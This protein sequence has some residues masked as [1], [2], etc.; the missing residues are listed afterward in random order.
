MRLEPIF[1]VDWRYDRM[2]AIKP[3][4]TGDGRMYGRGDA[5]FRGKLE[6]PAD[7]SNF[8]RLHQQYA[9]PDARG[10]VSVGGEQFVL[11]TLIGMSSLTDGSGIHVMM[12]MTE[13]EK[14]LWLNDVIAV[15]EGSIDAERGVLAMRYYRCEVE[16]LP[17]LP[18]SSS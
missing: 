16:H 11:F 14:H 6:G 15:G 9:F 3:S 12:F 4:T 17:R 8:P 7:W 10:T 2:S 1:D 13:D 5:Q 18:P